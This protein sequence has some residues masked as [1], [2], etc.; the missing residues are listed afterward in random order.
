MMA[1]SPAPARTSWRVSSWRYTLAPVWVHAVKTIQF[2]TN[3][4]EKS[5]S[6]KNQQG[7]SRKFSPALFTSTPWASTCTGRDCTFPIRRRGA[8]RVAG[9]VCPGFALFRNQSDQGQ[10]NSPR[11][12]P[13]APLPFLGRAVVGRRRALPVPPARG[14]VILGSRGYVVPLRRGRFA[15]ISVESGS[16]RCDDAA[17]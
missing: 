5:T 2:A 14:R 11:M 7:L 16:A 12:V 1:Q 4:D 15:V 17:C 10:P 13:N 6:Q 8:S 9:K 3:R